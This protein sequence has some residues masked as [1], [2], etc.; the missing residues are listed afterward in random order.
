[1][2]T[3][4]TMKARIADELA[5]ANLTSQ[6]ALAIASAIDFY[7]DQ[8]FWF[9]ETRGSFSTVAAQEWYSSTD[10]TA[11][12][13]VLDFDSVR[14]TVS[15]QPYALTKRTFDWMENASSGTSTTGDPT[16][17][18]F[19]GQEIRLYPVPSAVRTISVAY[20]KAFA[21]LTGDTDSNAWTTEA[22][23]LIRLHAKIDL[24]VNVIREKNDEV[25]K[26]EEREA[27]ILSK[28]RRRTGRAVATGMVQPESV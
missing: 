25:P 13:C 6:I 20:V 23:E 9:N 14:I 4:G 7:E 11:L 17:Y 16:D 1:M 27:M 21:A 28:L 3:L 12:P 2:A 15:T 8:R 5:R 19:Y 10:W 24:M 18:C 26:L 22:E